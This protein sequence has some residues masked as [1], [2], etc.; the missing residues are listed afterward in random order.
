[1]FDTNPRSQIPTVRFAGVSLGLKPW[2]GVSEAR[3]SI[4]CDLAFNNERRRHE[5]RCGFDAAR[6]GRRLPTPH[7]NRKTPLAGSSGR[8]SRDFCGAP[9]KRPKSASFLVTG[10]ST[11]SQ[12]EAFR[13]IA[14]PL[15]ARVLGKK[16]LEPRSVIADFPG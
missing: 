9:F 13:N 12:K 4:A 15:L 1:M 7:Q 6:S 3:A 2:D 5:R 11:F 14:R 8:N 16:R 10:A